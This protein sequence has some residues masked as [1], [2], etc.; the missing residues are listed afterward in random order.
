MKL[1]L[2]TAQLGMNYGIA[3]KTGQPSP[4][5]ARRILELANQSGVEML[6]TA[7][8][9][10]ESETIIGQYIR[11][12]REAGQ[13]QP[14][15][16]VTKIPDPFEGEVQS[17]ADARTR[18]RE[19]VLMSME[20]LSLSRLDYC[21][22]HSSK[23]MFS[24]DGLA[25]E[26]LREFKQNGLIG[27]VGISVYT[28]EDVER[29]LELDGLDVIQVP[30]NIMDT[31]LLR[32]GLLTELGARKIEIH[33]RSVFLQG[34]LL[35][36]PDEIP[37]YLQKA[38]PYIKQLHA[39]ASELQLTYAELCLVYVRDLKEVGRIVVGCETEN[40]LREHIEAMRLPKLPQGVRDDIQRMFSQISDDIL[41]P[42]SW[43]KP[44]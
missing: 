21:L 31:R 18:M 14:F 34:L 3:N 6:D 24:H 27:K 8:G 43:R 11:T 30:L 5:S 28:P 19:Q 37:A 40:Q 12:F 1:A 25:V 41:N 39:L 26:W 36:S 29:Y 10:G 13:H 2:G 16:I 35:M 33:V 17:A 9:Y 20:R 38:V 32:S 42:S 44:K 15:Q 23:S 7:S 22:L 4:S